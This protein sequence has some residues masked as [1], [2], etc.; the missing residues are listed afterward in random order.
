MLLRAACQS[1]SVQ[2]RGVAFFL[3][4][5]TFSGGTRG[6]ER[7]TAP[8]GARAGEVLPSWIV[9]GTGQSSDV[10]LLHLAGAARPPIREPAT[11]RKRRWTG[12]SRSPCH[13]SSGRF[14]RR[15]C[16][17]TSSGA[18]AS[19][20]RRRLRPRTRFPCAFSE[21]S[22]VFFKGSGWRFALR[23]SITAPGNA[24]SPPVRADRSSGSEE[25]RIRPRSRA[26]FVEKLWEPRGLRSTLDARE[27]S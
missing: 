8:L 2:R 19:G 14:C 25:D 12:R 20:L 18:R 7:S 16:R 5:P 13:G 22:L 1:R 4:C 3:D 9:R 11:R 24:S 15:S 27:S 17:C 6:G 26:G 21:D 23:P 10:E